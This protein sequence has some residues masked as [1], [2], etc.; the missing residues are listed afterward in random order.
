MRPLYFFCAII[1]LSVINSCNPVAREEIIE[2]KKIFKYNEAAGISSLDPAF[3][4]LFENIAVVNQ[5]FNGLVQMNDQ[6]EVIPAIAKKWKISEDGTEYTFYL[7]DDVY[8]HDHSVFENKKGRRVLASDFVH[9]FFRII[10]SK[11]ASPGAWIFNDVDFS[12]KSNFSGFIAEN[13]TTLKIYLSRPFQPFLGI[14]TMP[15]CFVVPHEAVEFFGNDFRNNPVGTGP[16]KFK[17]WKE[18]VK[19]IL[20]KNENYWEKEG[21]EKLPYLDGISISFIKERQSEFIGFINGKLDLL[22][23]IEGMFKDELLTATGQLNPQ[24]E[25]RF[26]MINKPFLK[27][28]YLGIFVDENSS[29]VKDNPLRFKEVRQ[30]INYAIDRKSM[31]SYLR[32]GIGNPAEAGIVPEGMPS[33]N[34][35]KVNGYSYDP[36]KAK[37]LLAKAGYPNGEGLPE[38]ILST[39]ALYLDLAEFIQNQLNLLGI[40]IK[41]D[42]LPTAIYSELSARGQLNFFR[43]SWVADY[44]DAENYLALFY[45]K[46]SAPLGPNYT[47]FS[48]MEYDKLYEA[49]KVEKDDR[50]RYGLYQ[51][52]ENI[53]L[54]ESPVIVLYYDRAIKFFPKSITG[55]EVNP[56]NLISLKRVKKQIGVAPN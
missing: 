5:I 44:P 30:A 34:P 49:S 27:T 25:S 28:D 37:E 16:F 48:N 45:S 8:F 33:Y 13:D 6:L 35:E 2:E 42:V 38:I 19:L 54:E 39:T 43:K 20:V 40:N 31:I 51:K 4:N 18:G 7:R 15:Y 46:N 24:Y 22:S 1:F 12:E 14:L 10:D 23:G 41:I 17:A 29:I 36:L 9:S 32:K 50:K 47:H 3:S 21:E 56:M 53:I 11:V 52:M 26:I 55:L